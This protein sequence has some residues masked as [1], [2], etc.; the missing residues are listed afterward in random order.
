MAKLA[1]VLGLVLCLLLALLACKFSSHHQIAHLRVPEGD[2]EE[3]V[4]KRTFQC[5]AGR[6][7]VLP[8]QPPIP[9]QLE[10]EKRRQKIEMWDSM[11]EGKSYQGRARRPP[12]VG[13]GDSVGAD[14]GAGGLLG[15]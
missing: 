3:D 8:G 14:F 2:A 1:C 6:C 11:Q 7:C 4:F 13:P 9:L 15:S 10:E 12:P 5:M